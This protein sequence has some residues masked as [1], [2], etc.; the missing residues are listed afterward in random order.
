MTGQAIGSRQFAISNSSRNSMTGY[1][2]FGIF[3]A[4]Y[5]AMFT[6]NFLSFF[7]LIIYILS[8][9]SFFTF[10]IFF[11]G[12]SIIFCLSILLV[13]FPAIL[14]CTI[15]VTT[16]FTRATK[17]IFTRFMFMKFREWLYLFA[18]RTG[19]RYDSF[20]HDRYSYNGYCSGLVAAHA[21]VSL[22]YCRGKLSHVK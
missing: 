19:L 6:T 16:V 10:V 7:G 20:R 8:N 11:L 21:A 17:A 1:N 5:F 3:L 18:I 15:F 14:T 2:S 22:L 9:Y 12:N 13:M 4:V